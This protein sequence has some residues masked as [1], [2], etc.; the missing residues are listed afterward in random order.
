MKW[1]AVPV[2]LTLLAGA[3]G[4][5]VSPPPSE[6]N[7]GGTTPPG[8][9]PRPDGGVEDG[10]TS[11]DAG[12]PDAGSPPDGGSLALEEGETLPGGV[13]GTSS[14]QDATAFTRPLPGLSLERRTRF[15]AGE[16]LFQLPWEPAP[17]PLTD[18]DGLGPLFHADS[19]LACHVAGGRGLPPVQGTLPLSSSL[20]IRL[21]L[22]GA[23]AHGEPVPLP[24]YGDQF[25]TRAITGVSAEGRIEVSYVERPGAYPDGQPYSLAEP[26][27]QL[28]ALAY[29]SL[30]DE[31]LRSPR[32]GQPLHGLG[33]L[34]AV[35]EAELLDAEDPEDL[36]GDGISG[37]AN[38]VWSV[39]EGR[40]VLGRFG[41]KANQPTLRQQ[42]AGA[43]LGDMG[44]TSPV[45][46]QESCTALQVACAEKPSGG[47]HEVTE[48]QLSA[49]EFH[50]RTLAVPA[51]RDPDAPEVLQGKGHFQRVGCARCHRPQLTTGATAAVPELAGQR[52]WP[53][54]DLLLHDMG[55][56]LADGRPDFLAQGREWR[57]PPLWGLGRTATVSGHTRL[58]HDGRA[59]SVEEAILWHGGEAQAARD[60]F[61]NLTARERAA[62]LAFLDS[63]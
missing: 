34:E 49:L 20:L 48:I 13:S 18:R 28:T 59:R 14:T 6:P 38:R 8:P 53:Y 35:P 62:L 4:Q 23:G 60:A 36:D 40:T 47:T 26:S 33:L 17:H 19:C 21:S 54:T 52:I 42:A 41:W 2:V 55:E 43:L 10:G 31:V 30:P 45:F 51:R 22:P 1:R 61:L 32:M 15:V 27:Y 25:Q 29:G 24:A 12:A 44:L 46:P 37:R 57:T 16:A 3:C 39:E 5:Q 63:L 58:L 11:P 50:A 9:S 7:D 56:A